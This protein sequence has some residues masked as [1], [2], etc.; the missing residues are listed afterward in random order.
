M[1]EDPACARRVEVEALIASAL[2]G[3]EPRVDEVKRL[4]SE[5]RTLCEEA[6][7]RK[8]AEKPAPRPWMDCFTRAEQRVQANDYP[9]AKPLYLEGL[10]TLPTSGPRT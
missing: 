10:A 3:A 5:Y 8:A 1:Q 7:K 6:A 2:L 9:G 4:Q